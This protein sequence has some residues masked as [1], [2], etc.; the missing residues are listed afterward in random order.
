MEYNQ[1][2]CF[3]KVAE[4]EHM[5][6]AAVELGISQPNLSKTIRTLENELGYKLF[7]RDGRGIRLNRNGQVFWR[8]ARKSMEEL[9]EGVFELKRN[10]QEQTEIMMSLLSGYQIIPLFFREIHKR[11]PNLKIKIFREELGYATPTW[12]MLIY[13]ASDK[14]IGEN[15]ILLCE[16]ELCVLVSQNHPLAKY[17]NIDLME[18][19]SE[20]MIGAS[21]TGS[22]GNVI[23][24]CCRKAGFEPNIIINTDN[25]ML[26][27]QLVALNVG[28]ALIPVNQSDYPGTKAL[29]ILQPICVRYLILKYRNYSKSIKE[30]TEIV[31][32]V[33]KKTEFI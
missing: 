33:C 10:N 11:M 32:D 26:T 25:G 3:C 9:E 24:D 23:D 30:M 22:I 28:V 21:N 7:D 5:S 4:F 19:A 31:V 17:E 20:P 27:K 16:D 6:Q 18:I 1:I 8:H 12:D 14:Q 2:R 15:E 13:S 29:K